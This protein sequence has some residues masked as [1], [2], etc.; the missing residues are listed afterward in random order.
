[1]ELIK[2]E[3]AEDLIKLPSGNDPS[4]SIATEA[5]S[6]AHCDVNAQQYSD[7]EVGMRINMYCPTCGNE[8][9]GF[10]LTIFKCPYCKILIWRD[11]ESNVNIPAQSSTLALAA[12]T[13]ELR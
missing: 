1:M 8:I 5:N 11:D 2:I 4:P 12:A 13:T 3:P 9:S 6:P 7:D 10:Y